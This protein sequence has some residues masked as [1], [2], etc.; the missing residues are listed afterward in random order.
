MMSGTHVPSDLA[1]AVPHMHWVGVFAFVA[2]DLFVEIFSLEDRVRIDLKVLA[3]WT[4]H[5]GGF[6]DKVSVDFGCAIHVVDNVCGGCERVLGGFEGR[7]PSNFALKAKFAR[8]EL[9][10]HI[11]EL[12]GFLVADTSAEVNERLCK[13]RSL[14]VVETDGTIKRSMFSCYA[15]S[16]ERVRQRADGCKEVSV[17]VVGH[18]ALLNST[19]GSLED[20]DLFGKVVPLF[21]LLG[22]VSDR[23]GVAI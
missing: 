22:V 13:L 18:S 14:V 16:L 1:W 8:L 3:I 23:F 20:V 9:D 10:V 21:S 5:V 4:L 17:L 7:I 11:H 12:H 6:G 15:H 19:Y 2:F